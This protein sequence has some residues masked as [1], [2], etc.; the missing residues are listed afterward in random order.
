LNTFNPKSQGTKRQ[1]TDAQ[2]SDLPCAAGKEQ[3]DGLCYDK[4]PAGM[5]RQPGMPYLCSASFTK[6]SKVLAPHPSKCPPDMVDI[7]GLCYTKSIPSG[8]VRKLL[9]TLD[10]VCPAGST[11]FGVGCTRESNWRDVA[12]IP[13]DVKFKDRLYR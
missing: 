10:Q 13:L 4:C 12:G 9:G 1:S 5:Q 11:D 6:D 7:A 3:V 2:H 8:Y